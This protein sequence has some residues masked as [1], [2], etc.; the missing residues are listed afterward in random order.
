MVVRKSVVQFGSLGAVEVYERGGGI[1]GKQFGKIVDRQSFRFNRGV[2]VADAM[3][4][5][6][7]NPKSDAVG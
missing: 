7:Y 1:V 3:T 4:A 5:V 2:R 6:Q